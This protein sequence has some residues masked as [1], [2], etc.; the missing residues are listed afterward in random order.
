MTI[1]AVTLNDLLKSVEKST[2]DDALLPLQVIAGIDSG[3]V[4][5]QISA[6]FDWTKASSGERL[7]KLFAWINAERSQ[8]ATVASPFTVENYAA[9][10][11]LISA[12]EDYG[13][14]EH[15]PRMMGNA[16]NAMASLREAYP[17]CA[18]YHAR[19]PK[20]V[21]RLG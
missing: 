5:G 18:V 15:L 1:E 7:A 13:F 3:D 12:L 2:V 6:G 9:L 16:R 21:A 14:S 8:I 20:R 11:F 17:I 19:K 4:A 10:D